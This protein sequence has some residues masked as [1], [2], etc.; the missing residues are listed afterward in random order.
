MPVLLMHIAT[1]D[2][3]RIVI[4]QSWKAPLRE[5]RG[6]REQVWERGVESE[7]SMWERGVERERRR[8]REGGYSL[9]EALKPIGRCFDAIICDVS[10]MINL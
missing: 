2:G 1:V 6:G 9:K 8:E 7:G 10:Q 4:S 5:R 3:L